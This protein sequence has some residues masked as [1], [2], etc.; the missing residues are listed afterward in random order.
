MCVYKTLCGRP[1]VRLTQAGGSTDV[2]TDA[3]GEVVTGV[4]LPLPTSPY[5]HEETVHE[6]ISKIFFCNQ[7]KANKHSTML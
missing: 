4:S 6:E 1:G 7:E 3:L 2:R 5:L